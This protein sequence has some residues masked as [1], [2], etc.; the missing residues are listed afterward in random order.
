[1]DEEADDVYENA[2]F[3]N[4]GLSAVAL[5]DYQAIKIIFFSPETCFREL[6]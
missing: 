6:I 2:D 1:M 5:Y 4:T 3:A